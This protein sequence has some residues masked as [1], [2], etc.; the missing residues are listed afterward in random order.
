VL[1]T[2]VPSE[3]VDVVEQAALF[4]GY[5]FRLV[6]PADLADRAEA[7]F[8]RQGTEVNEVQVGGT[9]IRLYSA[10]PTTRDIDIYGP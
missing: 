7:W 3:D 5:A 2:V 9:T 4:F 8:G 6:Y 1:G 10:S